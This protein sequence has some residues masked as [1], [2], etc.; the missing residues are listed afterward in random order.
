[1]KGNASVKY[2]ILIAH[3]SADKVTSQP[4]SKMFYDQLICNDKTYKLFDG[5]YHECK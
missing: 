1:M 3:G 4:A 2:P 5:L